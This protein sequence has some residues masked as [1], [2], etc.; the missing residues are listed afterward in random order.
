MLAI[1]FQHAEMLADLRR[2]PRDNN[3]PSPSAAIRIA[4]AP[5]PPGSVFTPEPGCSTASGSW[6]GEAQTGVA[7]PTRDWH[8][9]RSRPG[10][11][12]TAENG[13]SIATR[14]LRRFRGFRDRLGHLYRRDRRD[15]LVRRSGRIPCQNL[16]CFRQQL[17]LELSPHLTSR[18]RTGFSFPQFAQR[19]KWPAPAGAGI[20][21]GM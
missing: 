11:I 16:R 9:C 6:A 14:R 7:A 15:G 5:G 1:R 10:A 19:Y 18:R 3:R 12:P 13:G 20:P 4:Q 2:S 8:R 17:H 21:V